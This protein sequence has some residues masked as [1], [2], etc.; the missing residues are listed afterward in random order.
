MH[1]SAVLT[2]L[3][4]LLL[5]PWVLAQTAAPV[6]DPDPQRF[7][8]HV[9]AIRDRQAETPPA[10]GGLVFV[11]SSSIRLW[12]L[13]TAFAGLPVH[14]QG[15]GGA[16]WSDLPHFFDDLLAPPAPRAY[17]LYCGE[18][19]IYAGKSVARTLADFEVVLAELQRRAPDAHIIML[20][21]K[22]SPR[23]ADK[24]ALMQ[25]FNAAVG[26][27]LAQLPNGHLVN[28]ESAFFHPDGSVRTEWFPDGV[29]LTPEGYEPWQNALRPLLE[30]SVKGISD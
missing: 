24:W 21:I 11:G 15:I 13:D 18:N 12:K 6:A 4:T 3:F 19:D 9:Q 1:R 27:R 2:L 25:E 10:P 17:V 26:A 8:A 30:A 29:H 20:A 22:P 16:H 28:P 23:R 7:L 5:A 14:N